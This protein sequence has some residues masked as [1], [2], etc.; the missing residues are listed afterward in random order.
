MSGGAVQ[1]GQ[2]LLPEGTRL[3]SGGGVGW[4]DLIARAR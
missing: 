3:W 1:F 4:A 2:G